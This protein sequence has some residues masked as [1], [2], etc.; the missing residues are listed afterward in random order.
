MFFFLNEFV[1]KRP[2]GEANSLSLDAR[3][4]PFLPDVRAPT[5]ERAL[6]AQKKH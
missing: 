1:C 2:L 4:V 6:V 5:E 3:L